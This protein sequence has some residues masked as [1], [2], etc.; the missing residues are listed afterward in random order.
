MFGRG[1]YPCAQDMLGWNGV[2]NLSMVTIACLYIRESY[3]DT[4]QEQF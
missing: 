4:A 3:K 2:L 1:Y